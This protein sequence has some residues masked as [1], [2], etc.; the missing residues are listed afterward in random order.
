[1]PITPKWGSF[2]HADSHL[3]TRNLERL[4]NE[5]L[6]E[7]ARLENEL[8][9]AR[10]HQ[11]PPITEAER[12]EILALGSDLPQLW[13]HP[14]ATVMTRKRILR[15]LLEEIVVTTDSNRLHLKLHWKGG[16]HTALE[17]PRNRVGQHRYKTSDET[18]KVIGDLA[19]HVPD[20]SIASMLNR[21]G[22]HT[23]RGLTW[24][25]QRVAAFRCDHSIPVY[26]EGERAERGEVILQEAVSRLGVSKMTVIRIIKDGLL[27]ARQICSGAPYVIREADLNLPAVQRAIKHGRAVSRDPRQGTLEFQ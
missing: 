6:E 14:G 16:D 5:R 20:Q 3:V 19:R 24:T 7:V 12:A 18:E 22:V 21:L 1:M 17:V 25:Q 2:L 23:A 11:P 26:R 15:T 13:R 4:W 10:T 27:P 8:T 9:V